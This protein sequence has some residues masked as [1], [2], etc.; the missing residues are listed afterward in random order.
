MKTEYKYIKFEIEPKNAK[1]KTDVFMCKTNDNFRLGIVKWYPGWRRYCYFPMACGNSVYS[2]GC[3]RDI[4]DFIKQ[5]M[6]L[7]DDQ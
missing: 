4:A 3:L 1:R 2:E 5:L 6:S 7:R